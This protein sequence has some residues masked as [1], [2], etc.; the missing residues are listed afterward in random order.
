M[1]AEKS[2]KVQKETFESE[3]KLFVEEIEKLKR[4]THHVTPRFGQDDKI[5]QAIR[6]KEREIK[7]INTE[8]EKNKKLT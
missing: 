4:E 8:I 1:E 7:R 2:L 5:Q 6:E 3:C